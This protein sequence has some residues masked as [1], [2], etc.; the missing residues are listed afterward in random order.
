M[1]Q[2]FK[3][4]TGEGPPRPDRTVAEMDEEVMHLSAQAQ[5]KLIKPGPFKVTEGEYIALLK[6]RRVDFIYENGHMQRPT[7]WGLFIEVKVKL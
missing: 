5:G 7:Y 6:D 3:L 4:W 2:W 1:W